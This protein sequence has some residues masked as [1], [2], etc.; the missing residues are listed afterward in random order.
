M[1]DVWMPQTRKDLTFLE[2]LVLQHIAIIILGVVGEG[3]EGIALVKVERH[4]LVHR[5]HAAASDPADHTVVSDRLIGF[6]ILHAAPYSPFPIPFSPF[7]VNSDIVASP[8]AE[9]PRAEKTCQTVSQR[10][11]RSRNS[12]RLST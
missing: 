3:L 10:I 7:P 8:A 11:L 1:G 6:Q 4:N 12:E 5:T 9:M 2:E